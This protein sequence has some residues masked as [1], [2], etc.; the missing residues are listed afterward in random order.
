MLEGAAG[1][2]DCRIE[3]VIERHGTAI[4]IGRVMDFAGAPDAK[5]LVSYKGKTL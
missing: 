1:T 2:I 4:V 3:E 5:P